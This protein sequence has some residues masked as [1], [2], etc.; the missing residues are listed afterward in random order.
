MC[1]RTGIRVLVLTAAIAAVAPAPAASGAPKS[2]T[3]T[4]T[5]VVQCP[6]APGR[7]LCGT[8]ISVVGNRVFTLSPSRPVDLDVYFYTE[9]GEQTDQFVT[10]G[11]INE[12]GRISNDARYAI[13]FVPTKPTC[14][15]AE[16][17]AFTYS[18]REPAGAG[19]PEDIN[20]TCRPAWA[21]LAVVIVLMLLLG[22]VALMAGRGM[23]R[24]RQDKRA[25][26]RRLV[27]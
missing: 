15:P 18:Y 27:S 8:R 3:Q 2:G 24:R 21:K 13:V 26:S 14:G 9:K 17:V 7:P 1:V 20:P 5:A 22:P 23:L 12:A 19:C 25:A 16:P 11:C 4:G 10:T 6:S